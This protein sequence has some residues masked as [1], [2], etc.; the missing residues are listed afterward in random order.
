[1]TLEELDKNLKEGG[2]DYLEG[3]AKDGQLGDELLERWYLLDE[4]ARL[5]EKLNKQKKLTINKIVLNSMP[6]EYHKATID[7]MIIELFNMLGKNNLLKLREDK[8]DDST[9][10][11]LTLTV[12]QDD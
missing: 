7:D 12:M 9:M 5:R 1:M 2:L 10:Y 4:N 6:D 3:V 11:R 8:T